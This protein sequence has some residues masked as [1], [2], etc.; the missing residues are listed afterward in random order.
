[1]ISGNRE[2]FAIEA[3]VQETVGKWVFG[4]FVSGCVTISWL[5]EFAETSRD[6][7]EPA[8]LGLDAV[9]VF[10]RAH[11]S[12]MRGGVMEPNHRLDDAYARFYISHLGMSSFDRFDI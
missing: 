7:Y 11:G 9:E 8:L 4:I 1:M 3:E 12:A 2:R 10:R 6:R 5:R